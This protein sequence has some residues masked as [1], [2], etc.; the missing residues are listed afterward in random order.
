MV[1]LPLLLP[2]PLELP[3]LPPL[4]LAPLE[5]LLP[6]PPLEL[7]MLPPLL[8]APLELLL[9]PLPVPAGGLLLPHADAM[10]APRATPVETAKS[11]RTFFM[12]GTVASCGASKVSL[13]RRVRWLPPVIPSSPSRPGHPAAGSAIGTH[14]PWRCAGA[15]G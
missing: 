12:R 10:A 8:L 3:V 13:R 6:L 9:P 1:G 2:L 4:L 14:K 5:L 11:A 15:E 7:P